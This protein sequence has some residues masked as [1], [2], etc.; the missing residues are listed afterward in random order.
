MCGPD[1]EGAEEGI[2]A[3]E[4]RAGDGWWSLTV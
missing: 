4:G 1:V 2:G 3:E